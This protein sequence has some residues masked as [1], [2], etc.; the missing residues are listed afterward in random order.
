MKV[1]I[2]QSCPTFVTLTGWLLNNRNAFLTILE[3]GKS[4][5]KALAEFVS[6]ESLLPVDSYLFAVT[7]PVEGAG[8]LL[9]SLS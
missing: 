3:T 7:S 8:E 4:K 1:L 9:G 5:I 6:D 2:A